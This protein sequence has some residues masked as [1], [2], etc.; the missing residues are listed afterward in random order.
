MQWYNKQFCGCWIIVLQIKIQIQ[1]SVR[2]DYSHPHHTP[3]LLAS[4][5]HV[6]RTITPARNH[7]YQFSPT[8]PQAHI[9]D[10]VPHHSQILSISAVYVPS[11]H[12]HSDSAHH[13]TINT[14]AGHCAWRLQPQQLI[15]PASPPTSN[16]YHPF[17]LLT[18]HEMTIYT[19]SLC[20]C[21]LSLLP[22]HCP[23]RTPPTHTH[24]D[25]ADY[26]YQK[27]TPQTV[28]VVTIVTHST[29]QCW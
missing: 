13:Q 26:Q 25:Y 29:C 12:P 18:V 8:I 1:D 4:I 11:T 15:H 5:V 14:H 28:Y 9:H 3:M 24:S 7:A 10:S 2:G 27:H 22:T 19:H 20:L 21:C 23:P 17:T 6:F 16:S